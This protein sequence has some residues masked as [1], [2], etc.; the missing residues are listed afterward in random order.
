MLFKRSY[1]LKIGDTDI[2][3]LD[4]AFQIEKTIL[5]EP[6]TCEIKI[7]NLNEENRSILRA[8]RHHVPV[9]LKAGYEGS[10]GLLF[11]GNLS[12][13][14]SMRE[15]PDWVTTIRSGDGLKVLQTA[16]VSKSFAAGT[17]VVDVL[18]EVAR[19]LG[20]ATGDAIT[21]LEKHGGIKRFPS[22]AAVSGS[23]ALQLQKLLRSVGMSASIQDGT[24]QVLP[25]GKAL[26]QSAVL[27]SPERGLVGSPDM[28]NRL[29]M[30]ARSLLNPELFPG[31]K[32]K[33]ESSE[34]KGRVFRIE[35]VNFSG[36]TFGPNWYADIEA[37]RFDYA[38]TSAS[39][40][41]YG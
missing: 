25:H 26:E 10:L 40:F 32:V 29:V 38:F 18:K 20:L 13:V 16:R 23:S 14:F 8:H 35:R 15:G 6:N 24:L 2:S 7:W 3:G 34:I 4:M 17:L 12:E 41:S 31:R 28:S 1:E 22:G 21:F 30:R 36:E 19:T 33:I 9:M 37:K 11:K 5:F 27:L 39:S